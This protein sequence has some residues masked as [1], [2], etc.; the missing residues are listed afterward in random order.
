MEAFDNLAHQ[1]V[2]LAIKPESGRVRKRSELALAAAGGA[3]AELALQERVSLVDKRV[4][5]HDDRPTQD[6]LIDTMLQVLA[7]Q[8]SRKPKRIVDAA[9]KAYLKLAL[10]DL[11][12]NEWV[13]MTPRSGLV[14]PRYQVTDTELLESIKQRAAAALRDPNGVRARDACLGGL[15]AQLDLAKELVP[16]FGLMERWHARRALEKRDWVVK[17]VRDVLAARAAASSG[18]AAG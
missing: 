12:N 13:T 1:V 18:G 3:L 16:E 14:G 4:Q 7:E 10:S 5:V 8:K 17:A 15:A 6:P 9:R 11:V 2:L